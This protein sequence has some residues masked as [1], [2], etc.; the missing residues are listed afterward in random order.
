[1]F[2]YDKPWQRVGPY[3]M[4]MLAGYIIFKVRSPPKI[5]QRVNNLLWLL[6]FGLLL[7]IIFGVWQG[8]LNEVT[9]AFYVSIGHTAFG[10]GLIWMVLSCCWNLSPTMNRI[11]SYR[12][13]WPLSRLTYCTYL[14]HPV[15]MLITAY[16]MDGTV[17]L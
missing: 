6:S 13:L 8:E 5:S 15:I 3:I 12:C 16:R 1:D 9:T 17:H 14:I 11:L 4:G 10:L 7:L 2:L